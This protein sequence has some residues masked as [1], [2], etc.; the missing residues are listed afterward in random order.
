MLV[1]S[2]HSDPN[3]DYPYN[4]GFADQTG[5]DLAPNSIV[6]Y[7]MAPGSS[8]KEYQPVLEEAFKR[9][10]QF[11]AQAL[12]VSL[13]LDTLASDPEA[14]PLGGLKLQ[15]PEYAQMGEKIR[16]LALPT[17]YVQEG[18]Y[19]LQQVPYA[20]ANTVLGRLEYQDAPADAT[21]DQNHPLLRKTQQ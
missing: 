6:N 9:I 4:M 2:I 16:S 18:G 11:G 17:V 20:A 12:V 21:P 1:I 7:P 10:E 5:G 8:W 14:S 13:G 15:I 3:F 19:Y